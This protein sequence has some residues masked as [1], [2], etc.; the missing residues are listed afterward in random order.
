[1]SEEMKCVRRM[2]K[3]TWQDYKTNE[4]IL[5]ELKISPVVEKIQNYRNKWLQ[6]VQQMDG[7]KLPQLILKYQPCGKQSQG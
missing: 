7:D 2:A 4:D 5:S 1:M 3:H 6:H